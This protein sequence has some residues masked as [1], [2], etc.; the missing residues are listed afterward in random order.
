MFILPLVDY[1]LKLG[2][3]PLLVMFMCR[4]NIFRAHAEVRVFFFSAA[5]LGVQCSTFSRVESSG[6]MCTAG[7]Q[8]IPRKEH[9]DLTAYMAKIRSL[10]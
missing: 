8:L 10:A 3:S 7:A 4:V 9:T 5:S 1:I 6:M 2:L